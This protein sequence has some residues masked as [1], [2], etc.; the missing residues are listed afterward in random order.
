MDNDGVCEGYK[1]AGRK[2]VKKQE[3]VKGVEESRGRVD[4]CLNSRKHASKAARC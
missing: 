3:G 4:I 2:S 1:R